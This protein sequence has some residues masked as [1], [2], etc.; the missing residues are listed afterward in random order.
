MGEGGVSMLD[1]IRDNFNENL[2]RVESLVSTYESH[3]EAQGRGRKS[4]EVLDILRAAVVFLHAS[5]E[6]ALRSVARWKLPSAASPVLDQIPLIGQG[7][8]P[9]N[10]FS[11]SWL[12]I[13]A[14]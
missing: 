8:N 7:S 3:P 1:P 11:A 14:S 10:S 12:S 9:K 13:A 4:A 2:A 5:L 6:D